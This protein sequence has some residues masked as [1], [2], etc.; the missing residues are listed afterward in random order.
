M[1]WR[2]FRLTGEPFS[3]TPDPAFLFLSSIHAE[4][5]AA[6]MMGLKERRGITTMIGEVGTG[7]T[8]LVYSLLSNLGP[9]INTAYISNARLSFDGIVRSALKDFGV[10]CEKVHG[11]DLL[12]T[13]NEFLH[14]CAKKGTTAALVID[15]AQN[16]S[17]E[18]FED[19]RLLSNFET[20]KHKLLQIVLVGQPE[21]D[22]KLR[23]PALR[24]VTERIAV[25]CNVN[26]LTPK[27]SRLY[28]EHRLASVS[29]TT[30]DIFTDPAIRL[31]IKHSRGI[32][33]SIN[34]LC[35][36]AMLFAY[37]EN[38]PRVTRTMAAE[39]I[40]EKD[41][42]G[43]IRFGRWN[44]NRLDV[45]STPDRRTRRRQLSLAGVAALAGVTG[46]LLGRILTTP[47]DDTTKASQQ[48]APVSQVE[49][50]ERP[51]SDEVAEVAED[52]G[53]ADSI[54]SFIEEG[55]HSDVEAADP[56]DSV[57]PSAADSKIDGKADAKTADEP[58]VEN[59]DSSV[60]P[61]PQA[62]VNPVVDT[63][64]SE[65]VTAGKIAP[66]R[67]DPAEP[68]PSRNASAPVIAI[69]SSVEPA[70][71]SQT[72]AETIPVEPVIVAR[73]INAPE[74]VRRTEPTRVSTQ[75]DVVL[76]RSEATPSIV[77]EQLPTIEVQNESR[78]AQQRT[79]SAS[80][81][82]S[83][84]DGN[85]E[86]VEVVPGSSLSDLLVAVYGRYSTALIP[87][88][89]AMNPQVTDPNKILA[90]DQLRFPSRPQSAVRDSENNR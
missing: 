35:H 64:E 85:V 29:G 41:G 25:R 18:T 65:A 50:P 10:D 13:F 72:L 31:L 90:G 79:E 32:P 54:L 2:F 55:A 15:E 68:A 83:P 87:R 76:V 43:L 7:K 86:I 47:V 80:A 30:G 45:F 24:Q 19:L 16:L 23:D 46:L 75:S 9:E 73:A 89:Q 1:Y 70:V 36:N 84:T 27:E 42:R 28:I 14:D 67:T 61:T 5:F 6:L 82:A 57:K 62:K 56:E 88:V 34:I 21:L 44:S 63:N 53:D 51:T 12:N 37:G 69:P 4:A 81:I 26:P 58:V 11:V 77:T 60:Q 22:T 8:T 74:P 3:L 17:H 38:R 71:E 78:P 59:S 40:A 66:T 39:A 48:I 20:Y 49:A 33:R 52:P